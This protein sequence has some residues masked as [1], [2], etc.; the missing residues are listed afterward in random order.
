MKKNHIEQELHLLFGESSLKKNLLYT[1]ALLKQSSIQ[2]HSKKRDKP[3]RKADSQ[4]LNRI[5][6]VLDE[7]PF[8]S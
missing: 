5:H 1:I 8:A 3:D 7:M 4:H 6:E 2:R